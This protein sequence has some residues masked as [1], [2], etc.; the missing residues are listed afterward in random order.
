MARSDHVP[1]PTAPRLSHQPQHPNGGANSGI[2]ELSDRISDQSAAKSCV[3]KMSPAEF[4]RRVTGRHRHE[5][6]LDDETV[7]NP[8]A[9][10]SLSSSA[11]HSNAAMFATAPSLRQRI[12][13]Q[14]LNAANDI[15]DKY[16]S[17]FLSDHVDQHCTPIQSFF[18]SSLFDPSATGASPILASDHH[19]S[20]H[21][22][23]A[24]PFAE[25]CRNLRRNMFMKAQGARTKVWDAYDENGPSSDRYDT[26]YNSIVEKNKVAQSNAPILYKDSNSFPPI[27]SPPPQSMPSS[28]SAASASDDRDN[29]PRVVIASAFPTP[30]PIQYRYCKTNNG[31]GVW[32]TRGVWHCLLANSNGKFDLGNPSSPRSQLFS[33]FEDFIE[34]KSKQQQADI[35]MLGTD[36]HLSDLMSPVSQAGIPSSIMDSLLRAENPAATKKEPGANAKVVGRGQVSSTELVNGKFKTVKTTQTYYDDGSMTETVDESE[37]Q[38]ASH[39]PNVPAFPEWWKPDSKSEQRERD[40]YKQL[41]EQISKTADD[42]MRTGASSLE[43]TLKVVDK[44]MDLESSKLQDAMKKIFPFGWKDN[45][46]END[47]NN[48]KK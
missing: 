45:D 30:S 17:L 32:D 1:Q 19:Q 36:Q 9:V 5:D 31:L 8:S 41:T 6:L 20:E 23:F 48:K 16:E 43:K 47:K 25:W 29:E 27:S 15:L 14:K 7:L 12:E 4:Q 39:P 13:Q 26:F 42:F 2:P 3:R 21:V 18:P 38:T 11:Q 46:D 35:G 28:G 44:A 40:W 33:Q 37:D 24:V 10:F 22:S 34:W